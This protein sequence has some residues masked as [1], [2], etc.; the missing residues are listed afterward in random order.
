MHERKRSNGAQAGHSKRLGWHQIRH[1]PQIHTYLPTSTAHRPQCR[2]CPPSTSFK[3]QILPSFHC[4]RSA[5]LS[6]C[7]AKGHIYPSINTGPPTGAY[8]A[9]HSP[10]GTP[11]PTRQR[12]LLIRLP[13]SLR[14]LETPMDA[15]DA[16]AQQGGREQ[17]EEDEAEDSEDGFGQVGVGGVEWVE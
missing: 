4:M 13:A 8:A 3:S 1:S 2:L 11:R 16:A 14:L 9:P 10:S 15:T 7:E 12:R 6:S 5:L 17:D